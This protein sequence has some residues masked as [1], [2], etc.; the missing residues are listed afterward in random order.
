MEIAIA[1]EDPVDGV[2]GLTLGPDE[3]AEG[4][5]L[6]LA[7]VAAVLV[8]LG[9]GELD[10]GVILGLDQAVGR[11]A[12][13]RDV[14]V[15]IEVVSR[16]SLGKNVGSDGRFI[17]RHGEMVDV[18]RAGLC[19]NRGSKSISTCRNVSSSFWTEERPVSTKNWSSKCCNN[20]TSPNDPRT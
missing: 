14:T 18:S 16:R 15:M 2:V 12:L 9:D 3:A 4:V 5:H 1:L 6:G 13:A 11:R 17:N 8:D 19:R 20:P 7:G 10:R